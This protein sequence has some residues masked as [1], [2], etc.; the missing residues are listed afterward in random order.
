[1]T[2]RF[3]LVIMRTICVVILAILIV[4]VTSQ[5]GDSPKRGIRCIEIV[6]CKDPTPQLLKSL[7]NLPNASIAPWMHSCGL[8]LSSHVAN[9]N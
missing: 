5:R 3:H 7:A 4:T 9:M 8:A 6:F 2:F 1:M